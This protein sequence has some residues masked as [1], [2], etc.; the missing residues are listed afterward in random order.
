MYCRCG[1]RW[2]V[3]VAARPTAH[4]G[5]ASCA[6]VYLPCLTMWRIAD[7]YPGDARTYA[8]DAIVIADAAWS[9]TH[10]LRSIGPEDETVGELEVI[11]GFDDGRAGEDTRISNRLRGMLTEIHTHLDRVVGPPILHPAVLQLLD[12]FGSPAQIRK[13]GPRRLIDLIRP[14]P[15]GWPSG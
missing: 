11:V 5:R 7:L 15:R 8:H 6:V 13:A 1:P 10:T 12:Q 9:M 14:K 4:L 2:T 3:C